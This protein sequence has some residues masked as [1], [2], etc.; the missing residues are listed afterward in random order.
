MKTNFT[1]ETPQT[2]LHSAYER[3]FS[4]EYLQNVQINEFYK[5]LYKTFRNS[6]IR[7]FILLFRTSQK[8]RQNPGMDFVI[9]YSQ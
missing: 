5:N 8:K 4:P 1:L 2:V 9:F 3:H 7:T 6:E